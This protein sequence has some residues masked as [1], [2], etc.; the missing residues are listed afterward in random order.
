VYLRVLG[1]SS[2]PCLAPASLQVVYDKGPVTGHVWKDFSSLRAQVA[3]EWDALPHSADVI[4]QSLQDKVA[5]VLEKCQ[6]GLMG[7]RDSDTAAA[8]A[9][10]AAN[11]QMPTASS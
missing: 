4:S 8:A 2:R 9:A 11:Q 10:E 7:N 5:K 6:G 1:F 3:A